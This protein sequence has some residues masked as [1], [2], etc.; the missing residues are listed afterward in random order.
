MNARKNAVEIRL[1][2]EEYIIYHDSY[3]ADRYGRPL[4]SDSEKVKTG[5]CYDFGNIYFETAHK[6]YVI[7]RVCQT[8]DWVVELLDYIDDH[9][10]EENI[11]IDMSRLKKC[12]DDGYLDFECGDATLNESKLN[13]ISH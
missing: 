11:Y 3:D 6:R 7:K 13:L 4:A 10:N 8:F 2:L 5:H 9:K 1:G 12:S